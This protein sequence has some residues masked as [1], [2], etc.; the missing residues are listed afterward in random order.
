[1]EIFFLSQNFHLF[2]IILDKKKKKT[3]NVHLIWF[4][5]K[6]VIL[7]HH[8]HHIVYSILLIWKETASSCLYFAHTSLRKVKGETSWRE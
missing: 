8:V 3:Y 7:I 4:I 6:K 5:H 1:M 2:I